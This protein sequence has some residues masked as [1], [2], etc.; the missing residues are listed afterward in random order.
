MP[1][2]HPI[3]YYQGAAASIQ[4]PAAQLINDLIQ[5]LAS[6]E[7]ETLQA[8]EDQAALLEKLALA[9]EIADDATVATF[10]SR[11]YEKARSKQIH[12]LTGPMKAWVAI[13]PSARA[14]IGG[15]TVEVNGSLKVD[16]NWKWVEA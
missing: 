15:I 6:L 5:E 8:K 11:S 3:S 10:E 14:A 9:T 2:L 4:G 12:H 16:D 13:S 7:S 1:L